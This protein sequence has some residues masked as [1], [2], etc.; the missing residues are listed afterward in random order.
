MNRILVTGARGQLGMEIRAQKEKLK[1]S[2]FIFMDIEELD[3][4]DRDEV[5]KTIGRINPSLL[6][7]CAAYTAVDMA[8]E[9]KEN[10]F[11]VNA[12]A[13]RNII[14]ATT[15]VPSMRFV[16][17]S[18][19]FVFD[20]ISAEPY[21]ED[22]DPNPQ[23]VYGKSKW[24]GEKYALSYPHSMIIRTSWLYS[25]YGGNFVKTI[26]RLAGERDEIS[27]VNDQRG[28]PTWAA[29]LAS[30]ILSVCRQT[31]SGEKLFQAGIYH[32][33]NVGSC[34]WYEYASEIKKI[35]GFE[36]RINPVS[37]AE[38]PL[39]AKRPAYSVLALDKIK[40]T[41]NIEIPSWQESLG[42]FLKRNI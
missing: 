28:S 24:E 3:L 9:D 4:T 5:K 40:K 33:S 8:E 19:D 17:I 26:L 18:T 34:S 6:I 31:L 20:G 12:G 42:L 13:V 7:N 30:A 36:M 2:E 41:Y 27:V 16:H 38:F 11:A 25:E 23:S 1:G 35:T 22:A 10:A 15:V 21:E 32:Y 14:E 37:T 29:D 39:P